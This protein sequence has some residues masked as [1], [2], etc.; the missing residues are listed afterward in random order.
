MAL[1]KLFQGYGIEIE[2]MIV[3][4][5]TL[6]VRPQ[7]DKLLEQAAGRVMTE[8][9][10]GPLAWSNELAL[11]LVEVKTNGPAPTLEGLDAEFHADV[12]EINRFLAAGGARLLPG[13]MHPWM[14][15]D[16]E[17]RLWPHENNPIYDAYDRI[18]SCKGHGWANLQSMQINLPF[19][20][21]EE[22]GRLHA[23]IRLALPLLPAIA[24]SSPIMD[25]R[26]TGWLDSRM[27]VYRGNS[28][29][30]P[31]VT[32]LLIPEPVFDSEAYQREILQPMY[33]AIA[34]LDP[35]AVLQEEWLNSRGAIARFDR[36]AIEIRVMD[37]QECALADIALAS[38][39]SELVRL[40]VEETWSDHATQK[41][42]DSRR[43]S[44]LFDRAA[45]NGEA[46]EFDD[47]DYLRALGYTRDGSATARTLWAHIA[48]AI[49]AG[50]RGMSDRDGRVMEHILGHGTLAR[51]ILDSLGERAG[52]HGAQH[53]VYGELAECLSQQRLF[54]T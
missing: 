12:G 29:R 10:R 50:P 9:E 7:A 26:P 22:F 2:Y 48:E 41:A 4:A 3:D 54:S 33:Q 5:A 24:A 31:S 16:R 32:G 13:A 40:L 47:R 14:D 51:R 8:I 20:S 25:G 52:E 21:D 44:D 34:G 17:L 30:V 49:A 15:P 37:S 42:W 18:F 36:N 6:D 39:T 53:R 45:A 23:A 46:A 19:G 38:I 43:L 27:Q 28:A 11:H 35:E 1:L